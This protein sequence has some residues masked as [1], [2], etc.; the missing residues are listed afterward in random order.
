MFGGK[1]VVTKAK[2]YGHDLKA[3]LDAI[4]EKTTVV[5]VANPNNPTGTM[6][7]NDELFNFIEKVPE[8]TLIALDEAYIEFLDNPADTISYVKQ[9]KENLLLMRTFSKIYGLAGLRLGYGIA[10]KDIV[11]ILEKVRQP[12][13]INLVAQAAGIAALDDLEHI[14]RTKKNNKEG[15]KFYEEQ[16]AKLGIEFV[17]TSANF[18]LVKVGDGQKVFVELQKLGVIVRPMGG[19][20]LPEWVR[21]TIGTPQENKRCIR[22]LKKVLGLK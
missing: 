14:D 13:N 6:V 10:H 15:I 21:I 20:G 16:L 22:S 17:P 12:F 19:Y 9:G 1:L 5:F 8:H 11:A 4:T 18:I 7:S 2:N 3:M